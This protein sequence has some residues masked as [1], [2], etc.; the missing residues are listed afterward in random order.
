MTVPEAMLEAVGGVVC[1]VHSSRMLAPLIRE[2]VVDL[3]DG[4]TSAFKAGDFIQ[5]T[6]PPYA[7]DFVALD[8]PPRFD[9]A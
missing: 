9:E 1:K 7:L 3:P 4:L 2:I 5:I 6:A 8:V